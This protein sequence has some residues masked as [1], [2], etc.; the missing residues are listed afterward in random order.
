LLGSGGGRSAVCRVT[1]KACK[2]EGGKQ[3]R[4]EQVAKR[5]EGRGGVGALRR[6]VAV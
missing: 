4:G 3:S 6:Q 2:K 1:K 5:E